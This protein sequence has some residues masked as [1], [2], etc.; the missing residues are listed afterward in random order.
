MALVMII[1]KNKMY[2]KI[3]IDDNIF[4]FTAKK[5]WLSPEIQVAPRRKAG[6]GVF[7]LLSEGSFVVCCLRPFSFER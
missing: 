4:L 5:Q 1:K 6:K 2:N 7:R 3:L